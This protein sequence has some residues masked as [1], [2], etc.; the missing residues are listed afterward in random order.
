VLPAALSAA[1]LISAPFAGTT[2]APLADSSMLPAQHVATQQHVASQQRVASRPTDSG[3]S[4][5]VSTGSIAALGAGELVLLGVGA[6]V[7]V[8]ARRRRFADD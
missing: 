8:W 2:T 7:I 1:V 5:S 3:F 6:G 4:F